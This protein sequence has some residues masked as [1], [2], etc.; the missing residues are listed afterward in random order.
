MF[1]V[2]IIRMIQSRRM[3]WVDHVSGMGRRVCV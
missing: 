1:I 3:R 2:L